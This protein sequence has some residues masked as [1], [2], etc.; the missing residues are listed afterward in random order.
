MIQL[1]PAP[2]GMHYVSPDPNYPNYPNGPQYFYPVFP[3]GFYP[4]QEAA[5]STATYPSETPELR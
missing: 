3:G 1:P 5:T 2:M 4:Q